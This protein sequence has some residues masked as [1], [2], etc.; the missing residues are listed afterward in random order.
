[1]SD[2]KFESALKELEEIVTKLEDTEL[3]L[4]ESIGLYEKGVKLSGICTKKLKE[5]EAKIL[6]LG[7]NLKSDQE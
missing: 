3:P 5:A 7:K 6:E 2:K 1:M 4:E